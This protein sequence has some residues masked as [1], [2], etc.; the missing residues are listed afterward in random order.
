MAQQPQGD[1]GSYARSLEPEPYQSADILLS[2]Y[3][4]GKTLG[5]GSFGKV[6]V[7]EHVL[8]G[9]KVAVKILNRKKIQSL[10]MEEKGAGGGER[11]LR[12]VRITYL[13]AQATLLGTRC[14]WGEGVQ[15]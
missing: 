15:A 14:S 11:G 4:L 13:P 12:A 3:M 7:A 9:H 6:K 1:E 8:T 5:V 10:D 2:N